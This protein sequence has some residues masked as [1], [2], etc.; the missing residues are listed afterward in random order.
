MTDFVAG[1]YDMLCSTAIIENGLDIPRANTVLI[2][3]ADIFGMAQ[4]YQLRGRVGRA[5]ERA[6]CYL[7]APS[8]SQMTDE[9]RARIAA[10]ERF[11]QLGAGFQL[12]SLD[13]EL[14]GA[15]DLLGAEQSGTVA[16]VGLELFVRMLEEAIA[17]LR[18]HKLQ[19]AIDP[20]I[21]LDL[22]HYLPEEYV[23]DVGVR[24]SLYKRFA[25]AEDEAEVSDLGVELE[26]RFG[27]PP[28]VARQ[29]VRAMALKPPLRQLR[30][31]GCEANR[32]RVRLH[33]ASDAPL[34]SG[35][36]MHL[37]SRSPHWQFTPDMR[38]TRRFAAEHGADAIDRTRTLLHELQAIKKEE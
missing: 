7:I 1:R 33:F 22:E 12:A 18:G 20:E 36:L 34:D 35:K 10:L 15:G 17:E 9:A 5:S 11:S 4:L 26:D 3:G 13:M 6:Y 14:R 23:A 30:V 8:P 37:V 32:E 21:T 28:E 2:D 24:L 31:L 19:P 29:F 38:L 27:P 25:A 16:A